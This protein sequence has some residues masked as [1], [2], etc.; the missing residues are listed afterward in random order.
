M[1]LR[2]TTGSGQMLF[3]DQFDL[4]WP[5][6]LAP[7][8]F[9]VRLNTP[10]VEGAFSSYCENGLM[11]GHGCFRH[12]DPIQIDFDSDV[13]TVEMHFRLSGRTQ[14]QDFHRRK[15]FEFGSNQQNMLF[16]SGLRGTTKMV[17]EGHSEF[18]E[19]NMEPQWLLRYLPKNEPG[20]DAFRRRIEDGGDPGFLAPQNRPINA[21]IRM[22]LA[23]LMRFGGSRPFRPLLVESRVIE[24]LMLQFEQLPGPRPADKS[25]L[26]PGIEEKL[27]A[28]KDL[29]A[30]H[31]DENFTI[32]SL[33]REVGTNAF[34]L[35]NGF[36]GLFGETI[37]GYWTRL[38]MEY[39][40][41]LLLDSAMS[42]KAVSGEVGYKH[43][44]HFSTA[45][46]KY[47]GMSPRELL[48]A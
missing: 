34:T 36:K 38:K 19:I 17:A 42:I 3:E 21:R 37:H 40:R 8:D 4:G 46:K 12:A 13:S 41:R 29:L 18:L 25:A 20:F 15:V 16:A 28:V 47:Y 7:D 43:P 11:I 24:L 6:E 14:T 39:A 44:Q 9:N 48:R 23:D 22:L 33:A 35:Q 31:L 32:Q 1:D 45:F 30:S 26:P 10:E 5:L 2:I 27:H